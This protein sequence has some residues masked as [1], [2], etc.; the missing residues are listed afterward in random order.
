MYKSTLESLSY[1]LIFTATAPTLALPIQLLPTNPNSPQTIQSLN[2]STIKQLFT[3]IDPNSIHHPLHRHYSNTLQSLDMDS[4]Q[5]PRV[6]NDTWVCCQSNCKQPNLFD[7]APERCSN[8]GHPRQSCCAGPGEEYPSTDLFPSN[9]NLSSYPLNS[10]HTAPY[11]DYGTD[12]PCAAPAV[13][14]TAAD[15]PADVWI[16]NECGAENVDWIT[17]FCPV[18]GQR[19]RAADGFGGNGPFSFNVGAPQEG[20]IDCAQAGAP[21]PGY[22]ECP[23]CGAS[24]S[25]L[26]PDF[27]PACECRFD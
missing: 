11:H 16:C 6:P 21:A 4:A 22:W 25:G 7:L 27:C 19:S 15:Q 24:N 23:E 10:I 3:T 5:T 12:S 1:G 9:P 26:T 17:D 2:I 13:G 8:C 20:I 14:N 18:C